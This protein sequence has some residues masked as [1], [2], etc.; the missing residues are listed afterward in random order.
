MKSLVSA[1]WRY[2][3]FILSS[4][5]VDFQSRFV[6]SRLGGFWLIVHPLVQ[7]AIF[8]L[9]LGQLLSGRLPD[10]ADNKLAYAIYLL[11]GTLAWNLFTEIITRCLTVFIDNGNLLKKLVFPKICLPLIVTGSALVNNALLFIAILAV[12]AVMGYV[13]GVGVFWIPV[14][15]VMTLGLATGIGLILGTLNVFIRDIGQ[16][17]PITLQLGFWFTPIVYTPN[18][19]PEALGGLIK[20][21]PMYWIVE[22]YQNVILYGTSPSWKPLCWIFIGSLVLLRLSMGLFRRARHEIVDVL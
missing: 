12:F 1:V 9:V 15:T 22:A 11:S 6:R 14:L 13:P 19:L 21:N 7:A 20:F 17:V 3:Y 5:K 4:I 2:R 10:M 8:A 18:I 16:I